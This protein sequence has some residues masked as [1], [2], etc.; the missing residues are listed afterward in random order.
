MTVYIVDIIFKYPLVGIKAEKLNNEYYVINEIYT[1]GWANTKSIKPGDKLYMPSDDATAIGSKKKIESITS[2]IVLRNDTF[3]S[4]KVNYKDVTFKYLLSTYLPILLF[5]V[6]LLIS[7]YMIIKS[8]RK[9]EITYLSF[10]FMSVSLGYLG[11]SLSARDIFTGNIITSIS[12]YL[13]P[14]LFVHYL[15]E[16]TK[17]KD[18]KLLSSRWIAYLYSLAIGL[19]IIVNLF[20]KAYSQSAPYLL[21]LLVIVVLTV[22]LTLLRIKTLHFLLF[23]MKF[24]VVLYAITVAFFPFLF[25]YILPEVFLGEAIL[26][27]EYTTIFL[28]AIP[29]SAIYIIIN[30]K[31]ADMEYVF[32]RLLYYIILSTLPSLII[33]TLINIIINHELGVTQGARIFVICLSTI[34]GFLFLKEEYD[35]LIGSKLFPKKQ[36]YQESLLRYSV[37]G[38]KS[39]TADELIQVLTKEIKAVISSEYVIK[40]QYCRKNGVFCYNDPYIERDIVYIKSSIDMYELQI[41]QLLN[42]YSGY[43][44]VVSEN[45]KMY[46]LIYISF[47]KYG[48]KL[49]KDDVIWL[50]TIALNTNIALQCYLFMHDILN[51]IDSI[52]TG[53]NSS[54][55]LTRMFFTISEEERKKLSKEIHDSILQELIFMYRELEEQAKGNNNLH[56]LSERLLEAIRH[57][58][59]ACFDLRPPFLTEMGIVDSVKSMIDRYQTREGII[60]DFV[61][62]VEVDVQPSEEI[63]INIYRIIQ[64][65]LNNAVKHSKADCIVLSLALNTER[66]LLLYE[67]DGV[68]FDVKANN[69]TKKQFGIVGINER[70]KSIGGTV[71]MSSQPNEGLLVKVHVQNK[72]DTKRGEDKLL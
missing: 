57:T 43:F 33:F 44:L 7:L 54:L 17:S 27:A 5:I 41:G 32:H 14:V 38:K 58:R 37:D 9:K 67:D 61:H 3:V 64:E 28:F 65:L 22:S 29:F 70:V 12:L 72:N 45:A 11:A 35:N 62:N 13:C 39:N 68:G 51:E 53:R 60:I 46:T 26:P 18:I 2:L 19:T 48:V 8:K 4:I 10:F 52:R 59:E 6:N 15:V 69:S 47:K 66:L 55:M 24:K 1:S 40:V 25:L 30:D 63:S 36:R 56:S 21:A 42:S 20:Y 71:T 34:V 50:R 23:D 16:S 31:M 49:N